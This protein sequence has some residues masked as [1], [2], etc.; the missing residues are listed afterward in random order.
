MNP[1][2]RDYLGIFFQMYFCLQ[3]HLCIY[4]CVRARA[5]VSVC[6]CVDQRIITEVNSPLLPHLSQETQVIRLGKC[7]LQVE[8]SSWLLPRTL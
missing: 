1:E 6:V 7:F 8:P 3:L 4:V 2:P 5:R